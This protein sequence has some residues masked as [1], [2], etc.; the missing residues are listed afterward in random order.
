MLI[1]NDCLNR[2]EVNSLQYA[3]LSRSMFKSKL[4]YDFFDLR[5]N[6]NTVK[7]SYYATLDII[8]LLM[9]STKFNT[10]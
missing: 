7:S 9:S 1:L 8:P 6:F 2:H 3:R 4:I 10:N 5:I